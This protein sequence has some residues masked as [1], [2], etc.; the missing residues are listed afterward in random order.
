MKPKLP[1][2][3]SKTGVGKMIGGS[4]YVYRTYEDVIPSEILTYAKS[5]CNQSY[6]VVKY[7]PKTK[8]VSFISCK[9]FDITPEPI[10][11]SSFLVK[12][13]EV[14]KKIVMSKSD[15]W[16]YHHKWL[17]VK[18]DYIGFD[19][20]ASKQRSLQWMSLSGIDYSRI[21]KLSYWQREVL[22]RLT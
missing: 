7:T 14:V 16:I 5:L 12:N 20:E 19:V 17:F 13:N 10:I 4:L 15:P 21:G 1:T 18:D 9:S 11:E 6:D 3:Y 8:S 2:R 22:S